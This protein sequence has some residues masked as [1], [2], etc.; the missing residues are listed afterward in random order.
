[1]NNMSLVVITITSTA[2]GLVALYAATLLADKQ[3]GSLALASQLAII[4]LV[5]A[6]VA[7]MELIRRW[8]TNIKNK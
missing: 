3:I 6:G 1:M 4:C 2:F 8:D 5:I 7:L